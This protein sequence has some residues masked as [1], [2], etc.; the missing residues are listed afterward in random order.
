M[1]LTQPRPRN[2][3]HPPHGSESG[4]SAPGT[5]RVSVG[6]SARRCPSRH[7]S[8]PVFSI[9][10]DCDILFRDDSYLLVPKGCLCWVF[11]TADAFLS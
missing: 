1:R 3:Q 10:P 11:A 9:A 5:S 7:L 2:P 8:V 6:P 4:R